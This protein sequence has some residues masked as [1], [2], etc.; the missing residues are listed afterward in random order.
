MRGALIFTV[1]FVAGS[2]VPTLAQR[3]GG[4]PPGQMPPPGA[5]RVWYE[6][7]PPG[8]QPPPTNC[9]QAERVASRTRNARV[10]Y[11]SAPRNNGRWE[12]DRYPSRY[13]DYRGGYQNIAY[14]NGY[15]DGYEKGEEDARDNDRYDPIRHGRYR[16]ADHGYEGRYGSKEQ[17][18]DVYRDGFRAG[19]DA[20]YRDWSGRRARTR[21]GGGVPWPF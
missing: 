6:G 11:G 8:Q 19:Y 2:A 9:D 4:V 15:E 1:L 5:C 10:I 12:R 17:Y 3:G 7:R 16:S 14:R 21:T 13:P 20:G 18:K